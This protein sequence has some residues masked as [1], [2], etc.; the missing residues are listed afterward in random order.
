MDR[1]EVRPIGAADRS[2]VEGLLIDRWGSTRMISRGRMHDAAALDAFLAL[3]GDEPLGLATYA[4]ERGECE[5]VSL[6]SLDEGSGVGSALLDAVAERAREEG[7][8]RLWL[9][10]TNDNLSGLG[11]YQ[12]RGLRIVAVHRDAVADA[13]ALKPQIPM[14]GQGGIPLHDELELEL[15]LGR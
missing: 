3:R 6:D 9:V 10:T 12:R 8:R 14:V 4:L 11:F 1:I 13:R 5:L 2:L 15:Q 7:A